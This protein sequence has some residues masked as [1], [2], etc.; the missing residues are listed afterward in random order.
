MESSSSWMNTCTIPNI[1][2]A[3][4]DQDYLCSVLGGKH[5]L[6]GNLRGPC[7]L[8]VA[9]SFSSV[10][11]S[12]ISPPSLI[13][14][15]SASWLALSSD[16]RYPS[17]SYAPV[18]LGCPSRRSLKSQ[19]SSPPFPSLPPSLPPLPTYP[20]SSRP[21]DQFLGHTFPFATQSSFFSLLSST[22]TVPTAM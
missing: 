7:L 15:A 9:L 2:P 8:H 13:D 21:Q 1:P 19:V 16:S 11:G 17:G 3:V 12:Q 20:F 6:V 22:N 5:W 10:L 4:S 14:L 18:V